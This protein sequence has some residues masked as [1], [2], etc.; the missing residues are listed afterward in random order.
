MSSVADEYWREFQNRTGRT[1]ISCSGELDFSEG[2]TKSDWLV[3]MVISGTKTS[4][5]TSWPTYSIDMEPLPATG[6]IYIVT[7]RSGEPRCIIETEAVE[8]VPFNEVTW[9]MARTEGEDADLEEWRARHREELEDEGAVVGFEFSPDIKLVFQNF[10][11]IY[12]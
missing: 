9:E 8:I 6:E 12:R 4:F 2:G 7:D 1:E 5:F 3:S 10:S 11:V